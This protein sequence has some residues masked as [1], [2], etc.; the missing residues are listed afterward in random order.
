MTLKN[1]ILRLKQSS[2][3]RDS[4]VA[5][6]KASSKSKLERKEQEKAVRT[7]RYN[8]KKLRIQEDDLSTEKLIRDVEICFPDM[9]VE[10]NLRIVKEACNGLTSEEGEVNATKRWQLKKSWGS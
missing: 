5:Y 1:N 2:Y 4:D 8:K 3:S 9:C 6:Y 10:D 7:W